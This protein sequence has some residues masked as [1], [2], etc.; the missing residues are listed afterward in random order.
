MLLTSP[1]GAKGVVSLDTRLPGEALNLRKSMIKFD[2]K[3]ADVVEICGAAFRPLDMVL[4]RQ[5]IKIFE[6]LGVKPEI[7]MR[8]QSAA[9]EDLRSRTKSS[10]NAASFLAESFT[11][12]AAQ[13]PALIELIDEI[14]LN[15]RD[16]TFLRNI[17]EMA[18]V[19]KLREIKYRGRIPVKQG[20]TLYGIMDET[21]YLNEGEVYVVIER[22][23]GGGKQM[24]GP[25]K[26]LV[27]R[28]PALHPGDIRVVEAVD[29]PV[30]SALNALRNCIVFSQHGARDLPSQLSGGDLDGDLYNVIYD[31]DLFPRRA[32]PSPADYSRQPAIDIR[33]E[34]TSKDMTEFFIKFME[35]D[36]LGQI[37]NI[38][39]QLADQKER[40]VFDPDC[41]KLAEMASTAVDY[42]KTGIAVS[43]TIL[44]TLSR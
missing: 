15:F 11:S 32:I 41:I 42:S 44:P 33:R 4:N 40:G 1:L 12:R 31:R 30:D 17:V 18:V 21:G 22:A 5:F 3:D 23:T 10:I 14:G 43:S 24:L 39:L 29:V 28:S 25:G 27:T 9:V 16:D 2:A 20:V 34:V 35:T 38:H 26:V 13:F 7:F 8:L 36:Q 19:V 6:D 37:S